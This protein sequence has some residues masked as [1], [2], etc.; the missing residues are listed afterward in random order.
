LPGQVDAGLDIDDLESVMSLSLSFRERIRRR[1]L[2]LGT[3]VKTAAYQVIEVLGAGGLDFVV[4]DAEH[5]PFDRNALDVC[6]LAAR[7]SGLPALVRVPDDADSTI[8][9][10]LDVGAAGV[11]VPHARSADDVRAVF[12]RSRY[13]GGVRGFSNS[14]RAG[15]Y[16][17]HG[18]SDLVDMADRDSVV[19]CQ[20][21][22]REAI[23]ALESIVAVDEVDCL[24]IGRADLAVSYGTFDVNHP[25]V[26]A[27]VRRTCEVASQAGKA[28][29]IFLSDLKD[30]ARHREMGVSLFV[31]G[32]DQA[33]LRAQVASIAVQFG[34]LRG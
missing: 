16:G 4:I 5:A 22:D 31:I 9:N 27:A 18:L 26:D 19:I 24:F 15:G 25:S 21:E 11:L 20:I 13:R 2:L 17:R 7:A 32:S 8:L 34:A 29:G 1:E 10:V 14:P 28:V 12:R 30:V 33:L 3:F 23:D 6:V